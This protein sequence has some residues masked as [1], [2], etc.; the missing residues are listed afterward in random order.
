MAILPSIAEATGFY[1]LTVNPDLTMHIPERLTE[2]TAG[3]H[4]Q[5]AGAAA[6][7]QV[8]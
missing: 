7:S 4:G 3:G 5:S 6:G 8:R 1:D 2:E